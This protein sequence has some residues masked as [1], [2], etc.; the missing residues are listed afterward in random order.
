MNYMIFAGPQYYPSG[1]YDDIYA[2]T[3]TLEKAIHFYY[4][5]QVS[6]LHNCNFSSINWWNQDKQD[7]EGNDW[8]HIVCLK[9]NKIIKKTDYTNNREEYDI[10]KSLR[11]MYSYNDDKTD[12]FKKMK[13]FKSMTKK[14]YILLYGQ[15]KYDI[16]YNLFIHPYLQKGL[17]KQQIKKKLYWAQRNNKI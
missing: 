2:I 12:Y 3:D 7:G 4:E 6:G 1:G 15:L 17:T 9:T 10:L 16:M 14:N 13:E 11:E 8:S 5:S